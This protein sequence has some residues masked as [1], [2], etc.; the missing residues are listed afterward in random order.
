MCNTH[1]VCTIYVE[2][3]LIIL[4]YLFLTIIKKYAFVLWVALLVVGVHTY[5]SNLLLFYLYTTHLQGAA[6]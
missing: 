1:C 4:V 5:E 3:S 2:Y 6:N